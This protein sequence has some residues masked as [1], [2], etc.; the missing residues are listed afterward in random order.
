[1]IFLNETQIEQIVE[2]STDGKNTKF[3]SSAH[4]LWKRFQNYP[5]SPP[6]ALAVADKI[7]SIIF[8][9]FNKNRYTNLYEIVTVQGHEGNGYASKLW[10]K[11][12]QY[13]C[14][15]KGMTRLKISC[16]PD[17]ITWHLRNGLVFWGVDPTG[18]LKSDQ[19]LFPDRKTQ[20][21]MRNLFVKNPDLALPPFR[22][23]RE[24]KKCQLKHH[25][26]GEKKHKEVREAIEKT[27]KFWL[28][29][30]LDY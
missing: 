6:M 24:L 9:T 18:S 22:V 16:T 13:A 29:D 10:D 19:P 1:M 17:S 20:L 12:V 7:V 14:L 30:F 11:Y 23:L 4:N 21:D 8:A 26:F 15:D 5:K 25:A 2:D 28:G 27:G 3:L